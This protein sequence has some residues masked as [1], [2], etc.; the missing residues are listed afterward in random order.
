MD[1]R[2]E[3]VN[4]IYNGGTAAQSEA[5]HDV[6]LEFSGPQFTALVGSTGSGK[7]TLVQLLNGLKQP[8]SGCVYFDGKPAGT[9]KK[10][11]RDIRC[12]VGL[13]FQ[14]PEYQLFDETVLKD[15]AFGPKN[16]GLS[17][18]EAKKK[19]EAAI[20]QVGL[21]K[22]HFE[23]SPFDLSGG[24]KRRAA[25][26]GILAM[27]PE[28]LILDEPTAGLDPVGKIQILELVKKYQEEKQV[29]VIMITHNMDEAAEYAQ[30]II[31]MENG[32]V[33]ADGSTHEVFKHSEI[34]ERAGLSIP[35]A[36]QLCESL[37]IEGCITMDEAVE[38]IIRKCSEI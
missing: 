1:I 37:G 2:L 25:I 34:L 16:K 17:P 27:D 36:A 11:L 21:T 26:A 30:R 14:Y 22:E 32:R 24:E 7:S 29:T 12:R 13:V 18:A 35:Q 3:K 19:A 8:E 10:A 20:L 9:D 6:S 28:V 23:K 38:A 15:V 4:Y 33:A 5:L 31:V